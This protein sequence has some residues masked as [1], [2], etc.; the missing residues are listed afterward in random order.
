M[1]AIDLWGIIG[2]LA[3]ITLAALV[4]AC[5]AITLYRDERYARGRL[6]ERIQHWYGRAWRAEAELA[7]MGRR[8]P[9]DA[10]YATLPGERSP[11]I[12]ALGPVTT[13]NGRREYATTDTP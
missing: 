13:A 12:V 2:T 9:V 6:R 3:L 1:R 11:E 5:R 7:A 10:H 8:D 4:I